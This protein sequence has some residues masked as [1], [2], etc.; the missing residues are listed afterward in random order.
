ML[1][2]FTGSVLSLA[3][4]PF[5]GLLT[6][7]FIYFVVPASSI[8]WWAAAIP[9]FR[10]S[11]LSAVILLISCFIHKEQLSK[12]RLGSIGPGKWLT[13]FLVLSIF[14]SF[15]AVNQER[16]FNRC[17]DFFRLIITFFLIIKCIRNNKQLGYVLLLI[18]L[19]GFFLGYQAYNTP[20]HGGRLEGVGTLDASDANDF[21]LLLATIV[22]FG[23]P[24]FFSDT[25][26]LRYLA[27]PCLVFIFNGI[28]LCNSR[29][30]V[31]SLA[32][33]VNVF[34][35]LIKLAK[36]KIKIIIAALICVCA[37][38]CLADDTFWERVSTIGKS[39]RTDKGSG[40]LTIWLEGLEMV[41]DYPFGTGGD[42][43]QV[44]SPSY[45][46]NLTEGIRSSHNTYLLVLVEQGYLGLAIFLC[47][48]FNVFF[49][50]RRGRRSFL[51]ELDSDQFDK[52]KRFIYLANIALTA[53]LAGHLTGA[54]FGSRL[55]YVYYY[56]IISISIATAYLTEIKSYNFSRS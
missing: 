55:Y 53:A 6:Y 12:I 3:K 46:T 7:L 35:F 24:V 10:W 18:L 45:I 23:L 28:V 14:I 39:A 11:L 41:K 40:R 22:P 1:L 5:Y 9:D 43:F 15:F 47:L 29:G 42:G 44:L 33:S 37:F 26:Y 13:A 52:S 51:S 54:I 19:C 4:S 56:I 48:N 31:L 32:V 50:L 25:K 34:I 21:A 17:Y 8:N 16:S 20:R 30:A 36:L 49:I 2:V 38:A 27:I